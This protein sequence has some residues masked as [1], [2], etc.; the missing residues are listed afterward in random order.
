MFSGDHD[1]SRLGLQD[2]DEIDRP[3]QRLVVG[4]LGGRKGAFARFVRQFVE[5]IS[6]SGRRPQCRDPLRH[7][8]R[9][10]LPDRF[11]DLI[12]HSRG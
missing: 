6:H 7:F 1:P 8:G 2:A 3:D 9:E 10:A 11:N 5:P 4:P 12:E